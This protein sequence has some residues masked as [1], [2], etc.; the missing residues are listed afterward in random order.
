[1]AYYH[2]VAQLYFGERY[3]RVPYKIVRKEV[4]V[5]S[6]N[7]ASAFQRMFS[8]P[9]H[10]QVSIDEI[11]KFSVLN[12]LLSSYVATLALYAQE[13]LEEEISVHENL[14]E[15]VQNTETLLKEAI[16]IIEES[17]FVEKENI[18]IL[19]LHEKD[20]TAS[21]SHVTLD[22]EMLIAEQFINIQKVAFDICKISQRIK[23]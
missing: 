4:Y 10:K 21:R 12:H 18:K 16:K 7:L 22:E 14:E 9:K 2:Q 11:H 6:A 15:I 8:E 1:M 19:S 5:R 3:Q 23:L 20:W 13:H 17:E